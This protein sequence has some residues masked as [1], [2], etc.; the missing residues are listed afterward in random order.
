MFFVPG[1]TYEPGY[2]MSYKIACAHKLISLRCL[3]GD[4]MNPWL[5]IECPVKNWSNCPDPH[6][7]LSLHWVNMQFCRKHSA[8]TQMP[9]VLTRAELVFSLFEHVRKSSNCKCTRT[10]FI[11]P[12]FKT[13]PLKRF[14]FQIESCFFFSVWSI[15]IIRLLVQR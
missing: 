10:F 2:S 12:T 15:H 7:G 6:N 3:S 4:A 1:K 8:P 9:W 14:R 11:S 5:P 13:H